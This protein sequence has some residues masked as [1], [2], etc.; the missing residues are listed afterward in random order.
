[1]VARTSAERETARSFT[2]T[3]YRA[4]FFVTTTTTATKD[5][6]SGDDL[7]QPNLSEEEL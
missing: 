5:N 6:A 2:T 4:A 1:M 7:S 3:D